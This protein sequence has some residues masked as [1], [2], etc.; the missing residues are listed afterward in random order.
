[1]NMFSYSHIPDVPIT[2]LEGEYPGGSQ[3]KRRRTSSPPYS[4]SPSILFQPFISSS[5]I[6][7]S[8]SHCH[9]WKK[10][11]VVI[12]WTIFI[13][14]NWMVGYSCSGGCSREEEEWEERKKE[15]RKRKNRQKG[16]KVVEEGNNRGQRKRMEQR[17]F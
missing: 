5:S 12:L 8:I 7:H 3:E 10:F 4:P 11:C 2:T 15:R 16:S 17:R 14:W 6:S 1:M 13:I 9:W